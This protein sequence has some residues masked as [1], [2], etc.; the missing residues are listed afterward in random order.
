MGAEGGAAQKGPGWRINRQPKSSEVLPWAPAAASYCLKNHG[1]SGD[2][3]GWPVPL[4]PWS[5]KKSCPFSCIECCFRLLY[6]SLASS[7]G[8]L[9]RFRSSS[10]FER[11]R[12]YRHWGSRKDRDPEWSSLEK[13]CHSLAHHW[14]QSYYFQLCLF[15]F[16]IWQGIFAACLSHC[17]KEYNSTSGVV[18]WCCLIGIKSCGWIGSWSHCQSSYHS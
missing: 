13:E 17:F 18:G 7:T 2:G 4:P 8:A 5:S 16:W 3:A 11:A 10:N 14:S 15:S 9:I 6:G 1:W 12:L